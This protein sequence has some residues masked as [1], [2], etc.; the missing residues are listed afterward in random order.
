MLFLLAACEVE[1][2]G[3]VVGAASAP[4]AGA[5][6]RADGCEAVTAADGLFRTR[7]RREV[8]RFDVSHPTH[9]TAVLTIDATGARSPSA[10]EVALQPWP[11][12]VGLYLAAGFVPLP[13]APLKRR[14]E[15][16]RQR[17]CLDTPGGAPAAASPGGS[18]ELFEVEGYQWRV[19]RL[20]TEGCAL[21][22]VQA[23]GSAWWSPEG[24]RVGGLSRTELATGRARVVVP[25]GGADLI[26][27]AWYDGFLVP[28]DV[29]S[30]TWLAWRLTAPRQAG[31]APEGEGAAGR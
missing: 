2:S 3:R 19:Y 11:E 25:A 16:G 28:H 15:P 12:A 20:D 10:V 18:T 31:A 24:E 9:A 5:S 6:L 22:M 17:F 7:C 1:I 21:A 13:E 23:A 8:Y 26:A 27:L 14:V 29:A 4:V 30:D